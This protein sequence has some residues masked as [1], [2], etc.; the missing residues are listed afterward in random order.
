MGTSQMSPLQ[1]IATGDFHH[2]GLLPPL[3]ADCTAFSHRVQARKAIRL[4][5]GN[6]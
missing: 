4:S 1:P 3:A 5:S 6:I 2:C